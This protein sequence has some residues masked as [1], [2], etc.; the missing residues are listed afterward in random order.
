MRRD[1]DFR[2]GRGFDWLNP[3]IMIVLAVAGVFFIYS[4]QIYTGLTQYKQQIVWMI[5]GF[6]AYFAV[7]QLNYAFFR[8]HAHWIYLAALVGLLLVWSPIGDARG[9]SQRWIDLRFFSIQ[10]S[11]M[12][13]LGLLVICA[14]TLAGSRLGK[15]KDSFLALLTIGIFTAIPL[16]MIFLQP[17]LGS[18]LVIPPMVLALLWAANLSWKFFA[19]AIFAVFL[20][21]S[22]VSL[23][24]LGYYQ[25]NF[26][27]TPEP[28]AG[29][30]VDPAPV[31]TFLP[32]RDYQR[33]RILV[34]AAPESVDPLGAGWNIRQSLISVGSGGLLGK[35]WGQGTQAQLGYLP[36]GVAHNDF[37]FSVLAE[38]KG[39]L[40][41]ALVVGLYGLLLTNCIRI[42]G[43]AKDKFGMLLCVGVMMIFSVHVFVN[44]GMTIGLMP[45][46]GLPLPFLSYGGS[47]FVSC[48]ILLGLVQSVYRHRKEVRA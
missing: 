9:G 22:I 24:V 45:I 44:I 7:G 1:F 20:L 30:R 15:V 35:G 16:G 5:L 32:I 8:K 31:Q 19:V 13:K 26:A 11:E 33:T 48:C 42:A 4:A 28:E 18:S 27:E 47:F 25:Q 39:F 46:T 37:I 2:S 6:I 14:A 40:G 41:S 38:E 10:P 21:V 12:A 36:R 43:K 34:F 23:D 17:D 3:A 29:Q